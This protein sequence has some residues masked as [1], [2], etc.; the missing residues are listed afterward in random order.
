MTV[1]FLLTV[2]VVF[3]PVLNVLNEQSV[4]RI[5]LFIGATQVALL[6]VFGKI[7]NQLSAFVVS[8]CD[9]VFSFSCQVWVHKI[10]SLLSV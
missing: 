9:Y 6:A 8:K 10:L 5:A 1:V 2:L 7:D 3:I 4:Q